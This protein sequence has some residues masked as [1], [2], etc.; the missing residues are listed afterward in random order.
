MWKSRS[1][2]PEE[3]AKRPSPGWYCRPWTD[4]R[5]CYSQE[6]D[7]VDEYV[8]PRLERI[9]GVSSSN[10]YGGREREIQV[11]VDQRCPLGPEGD[12]P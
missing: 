10:I 1:S 7:F 6:Y 2:N 12:H 5:G 4:M 11:I 3:D 9:S 8:K